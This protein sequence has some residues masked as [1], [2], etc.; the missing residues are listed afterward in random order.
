ML[1]SLSQK[2]IFVANLKTASTAIE[3]AIGDKADIKIAATR[4]GKHDG[5]SAISQ[6]FSWVKRY[7][8]YEDFFVFGVMREPVDYLLSLYN[9]HQKSAFDGKQ[10]STKGM[11]FDEFLE[12][13]CARSWQAKPQLL[14]FADEHN[15]LH[16]SYVIDLSRLSEEFSEICARLGL[17]PVDLGK[18]NSSPEVLRR[19]DLTSSQI[20]WVKTAYSADYAFLRGRPQQL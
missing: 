16:M 6:K 10:Q 8:P 5:L 11:A 2:F 18:K 7:V 19:E 12:V 4:F 15:R 9:S 1:L 3:A 14:R 17:G 20:A 13:W